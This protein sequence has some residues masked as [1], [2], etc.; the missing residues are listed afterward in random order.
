MPHQLTQKLGSITRRFELSDDGRLTIEVRGPNSRTVST[1]PLREI[2]EDSR[3]VFS[4]GR[5]IDKQVVAGV[6]LVLLFSIPG[7]ALTLRSGFGIASTAF[8]GIALSMAFW[9]WNAFQSL[10]LEAFD[11]HV[12]S[13]RNCGP[14]A[15]VLNSNLPNPESFARFVTT[16][17]TCI[18]RFK[19][20]TEH[21]PGNDP[22]TL[23][24]DL[25]RLYSNGILT[26][27]EFHSAKS[28]VLSEPLKRPEVGF[29]ID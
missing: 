25:E 9:T 12:Y 10:R 7:V 6:I 8:F 29:R 27:T 16:L 3:Q 1:I 26:E 18:L 14:D 17:R 22:A 23:L 13:H 24:E 2:S 20:H 5:M 15:F 19:P 11:L 21:V 28:R 4:K